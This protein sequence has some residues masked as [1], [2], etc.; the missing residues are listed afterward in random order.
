MNAER[1]ATDS[2]VFQAKH[3]GP[4]LARRENLNPVA[5]RGRARRNAEFLRASPGIEF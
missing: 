4:S 1:L 3:S 5:R 2:A